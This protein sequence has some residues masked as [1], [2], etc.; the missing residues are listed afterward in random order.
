MNFYWI[1]SIPN[2]LLCVLIIF[3]VCTFSAGGIFATRRMV[4][5]IMGRPPSQN[6]VVGIYISAIGV[7]YGITLGLIAVGAWDTYS[8]INSKADQEAAA[9]AA[10]YRNVTNYPEPSR[11]EFQRQ[12]REYTQFI[13]DE[14]WPFQRQGQIPTGGL[15]KVQDLQQNLNAF[16]PK[17]QAQVILHAATLEKFDQMTQLG[18][19]RL[20]SVQTGLPSALW[21][22]VILGAFLN[23]VLTWFLVLNDERS[24][25][26][27]SLV[28]AAMMGL[29]IFLTAAMDN[30][31]RG[32]F[33]V[34]A[35]AFQ[36]VY[37]Q[38][39]KP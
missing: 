5:R 28:F 31:F 19:L 21:A 36:L 2:W 29:L 18:R 10:L 7:F 16:E 1:Y 15:S 22:V 17:T 27:L 20:Q 9:V 25:I 32:E 37:E 33:S 3:S 12:V 39:M 6:D 8:D 24:H 30:P 4:R 34:S 38:I 23:I 14:A 13:I 11:T 35:A 26:W